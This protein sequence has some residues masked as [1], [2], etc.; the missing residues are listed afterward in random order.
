[1]CDANKTIKDIVEEWLRANNYSG[2][3]DPDYGCGCGLDDFMP[4]D[5]PNI[6][7]CEAAFQVKCVCGNKIYSRVDEDTK[8]CHCEDPHPSY[9]R[10]AGEEAS[11]E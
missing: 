6:N 1:M 3:C 9:K 10:P 7:E 11:H 8:E 5:E 2:L 4:C